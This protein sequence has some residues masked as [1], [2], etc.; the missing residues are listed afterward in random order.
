M[1]QFRKYRNLHRKRSFLPHGGNP[2]FAAVRPL[3]WQVEYST[4]QWWSQCNIWSKLM[5]NLEW[6]AQAQQIH[7]ISFHQNIVLCVAPRF[8]LLYFST[9][10]IPY[11]WMALSVGCLRVDAVCCDWDSSSLPYKMFESQIW[12]TRKWHSMTQLFSRLSLKHIQCFHVASSCSL[13]HFSSI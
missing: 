13:P 6:T 1:P 9:I 5:N 2:T 11:A 10:P 7:L 12:I 8:W 4:L 3:P